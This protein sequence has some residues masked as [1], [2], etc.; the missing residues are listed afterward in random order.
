MEADLRNSN[1]ASH[2]THSVVV[3]ENSAAATTATTTTVHVTSRKSFHGNNRSFLCFF[4]KKYFF[5][6]TDLD[7]W[8]P[9]QK[10]VD[11]EQW[12]RVKL[13]LALANSRCAKLEE[14]KLELL[15]HASQREAELE[16][17]K[18]AETKLSSRVQQLEEILVMGNGNGSVRSHGSSDNL[19]S[20]EDLLNLE[21]IVGGGLGS[22]S[23]Q[24]FLE[25]LSPTP[26]PSLSAPTLASSS[27]SSS[28][29]SSASPNVVVASSTSSVFESGDDDL[30]SELVRV[31]THLAMRMAL[32]EEFSLRLKKLS[33]M[34]EAAS[35]AGVD[36][37]MTRKVIVFLRVLM[38]QAVLL[39]ALGILINFIPLISQGQR[40]SEQ[41]MIDL[42]FAR[43]DA[44]S[45]QAQLLVLSTPDLPFSK[46]VG[47][48][49]Q[50]CVELS[51]ANAV[52]LVELQRL[53]TINYTQSNT[54]PKPKKGSFLKMKK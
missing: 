47:Q 35:I 6:Q 8:T 20:S 42:S 43:L 4:K 54:P 32:D 23:V 45:D 9:A 25:L 36:R 16:R 40:L 51:R 14:E 39:C 10:L 19:R 2:Q 26:H 33:L 48:H 18:L 46:V 31:K 34:F 27:V 11:V 15:L 5:C 49:L 41:Q 30:L 22:D 38:L 53:R 24:T 44:V 17:A 7:S 28:S 13:Q 52:A 21:G 12:E 37:E 3:Q 50:T 1:P 29:P